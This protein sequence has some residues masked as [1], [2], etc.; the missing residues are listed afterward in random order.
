MEDSH[1]ID[2]NLDSQ[3]D[4]SQSNTFFAVYDGHGG[5]SASRLTTCWLHMLSVF[6]GASVAKFAGER[7][8]RRLVED[9]A[10]K[11]RRFPEALKN[12]FLGSDAEMKNSK[13][14]YLG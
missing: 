4:D 9:G 13:C 1:A 14:G 5:M 3:D 2:L 8:H 11:E 12:A 7:V 10:Y 6:Q